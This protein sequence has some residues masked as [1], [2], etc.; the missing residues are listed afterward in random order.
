MVSGLAHKLP[1]GPGEYTRQPEDVGRQFQE[2]A[3][4][5]RRETAYDSVA[6]V[7][8]MN[9]AY[10]RI[11]GLGPAVLPFI[12]ADLATR[13]GQWFWALCAITGENPTPAE[14]RGNGA[15]MTERWLEWGRE[16]GLV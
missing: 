4:Q 8:F 1:D 5:W 12:L 6:S 10:Q 13:G 9:W 14:E 11:I 7:V 16:R 15:R 3:D 2:L